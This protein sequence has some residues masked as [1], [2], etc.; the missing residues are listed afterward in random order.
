V[1]EKTILRYFKV[2]PLDIPGVPRQREA[3]RL[4]L[5][6]GKVENL[7]ETRAGDGITT[8]TTSN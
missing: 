3:L 2:N 1:S 5:C 6:N 8:P 4:F 7:L